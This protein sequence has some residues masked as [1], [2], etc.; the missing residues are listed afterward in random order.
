MLKICSWNINGIRSLSKPLKRHLDALN[1]DV[2]CFQETKAT[3]VPGSAENINGLRDI[4]F[5]GR[6]VIVQLETSENGRLLSIISVYCPRVDPEKADRVI[7]RDKFLERLKFT[8]IKL[9]SGGSHV[10]IAGDFN[11]CHKPIDHCCLSD[12]K[13]L[14]R[15]PIE[16]LD[17]MLIESQQLEGPRPSVSMVDL[18]RLAYPERS[19]AFTCWSVQTGARKTNYGTRIDYILCDK[20]LVGTF[21]KGD[22]VADI[23]PEVEGSDHCP[24]WA[25]LPVTVPTGRTSLP[26][27]CTHFWPQC[28]KRQLQLSSF[29]K[30]VALEK[31]TQTPIG[32]VVSKR[33]KVLTNTDSKKRCKQSLLNFCSNTIE[34]SSKS[35]G[36]ND[37]A[38]MRPER[39]GDACQRCPEFE[40]ANRERQ[41]AAAQQWRSLLDCGKKAPKATVPLCVGHREPCV[42]RQVK[43]PDSKHRGREFWACARPIGAP[44]NPLARCNTFIWK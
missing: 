10:V 22:V 9:I 19:E 37:Q 8:V 13:N 34:I 11:I 4:D 30:S 39:D 29:L 21:R 14:P 7:Y 23:M 6:L 32:N 31:K 36:I 33:T 17:S 27:L 25:L 5:E 26:P 35:A 2:I 28:Q 24:V 18:F 16:W 20:D 42:S 44:T 41:N 1:A 15:G 43:R 38:P 40:L 12:Y 3:F